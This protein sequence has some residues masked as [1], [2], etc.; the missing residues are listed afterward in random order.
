MR[1]GKVYTKA[2]ISLQR[3]IIALG[4]YFGL[5]PQRENFASLKFVLP[6]MPKPNVNR[7][8]IGRIGTPTQNSRVGH[9][10]FIFLV[11]ISFVLGP[12]FQWNMGLID[13]QA[14]ASLL[15][16]VGQSKRSA[17]MQSSPSMG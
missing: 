9:V 13:Q 7:W 15:K 6:P 8:N 2:Y 4:P 10:D 17:L 5:D 14:H 3:K 12:I 1:L 16:Y 11:S